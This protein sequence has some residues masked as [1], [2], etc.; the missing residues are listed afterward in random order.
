LAGK[1]FARNFQI[2]KVRRANLPSSIGDQPIRQ[3]RQAL[4]VQNN[5]DEVV[6]N[7]ASLKTKQS[8]L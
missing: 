7:F 4:P 2:F 8:Q 6:R 1:Y 3:L 5:D